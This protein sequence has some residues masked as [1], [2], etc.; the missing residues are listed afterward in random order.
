MN[1]PETEEAPLATRSAA[2]R[3]LPA[4]GYAGIVLVV[5]SWTLSWARIDPF[6]RYSFFPLWFGY[7]TTMDALV[8]WRQGTS[9]YTRNIWK[10]V[11]L[12][13]FSSLFWWAFEGANMP[14]QNWHYILDQRYSRFMYIVIASLDFSTVLPAVLETAE[15]VTSFRRFQ[16]R[17]P[18]ANP[19]PLAPRGIRLIIFGAG[20]IS[21]IAP[22][23]WPTQTFYLI[24]VA[25]VL[26]LDPINNTLRQKSSL[27]HALALD[28]RFFLALP[29]SGLI[30]GFFWE[31]WNWLA[32]PK[33]YYTVPYVGFAKVFEMPILGYTGYLPFALELFALYQLALFLTHQRNDGLAF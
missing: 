2:R 26:L 15:F 28:W 27:G 10:V 13:I 31:M 7:I 20:I 1:F 5:L 33:W 29:L 21:C 32:M 24:W 30:C 6:F 22:V 19:G 18:P 11:Q 3:R 9:F 14:V 23:L 17:L 25:L 4:H 8:Y 12:F 16:P